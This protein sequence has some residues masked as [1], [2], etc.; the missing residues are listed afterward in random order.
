MQRLRISFKHLGRDAGPHMIR[1]GNAHPL[2]SSHPVSILLQTFPP[3]ASFLAVINAIDKMHPLVH[4]FVWCVWSWSFW[5]LWSVA[6]GA[7][8]IHLGYA[9]YTGVHNASTGLTIWKGIRY[10]QPPLGPLRW[11]APQPPTDTNRLANTSTPI[12]ASH[13]GPSCPQS[14]PNVPGASYLFLPGSEDCLFLNVYAPA[15]RNNSAVWPVLVWFHGGGYGEGDATQDLSPFL[16]ATRS[17]P[18]VTV[19]VQYRLGAF[20]FLAG[21]VVR[22]KGTLNAGLLD[23]RAALAWVQQYITLFGGDPSRVTLSGESAG[24]GS[25]LLHAASPTAGGLF[26]QI[27]AAS[28]WIPTQPRYDSA[29]VER[30]YR[31]FVA[32]S[33]CAGTADAWAC[34]VAQNTTTLQ[35]ASNWVSATAPTPHGNWAWLPVTDDCLL[36][37]PPSV[38]LQSRVQGT[39][40][41]I[42]VSLCIPSAQS[43]T[44]IRPGHGR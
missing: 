22:E 8:T 3:F 7:S 33:G 13:F 30:H 19:S 18:I 32:S 15:P 26:H 23:Q 24:A 39:H 38:L 29:V 1:S 10:A 37:G 6:A 4:S 17:A 42:G 12:L 43:R 16:T 21:T 27:W 35:W 9:A 20:G 14:L 31:D 28:P 40:A 2:V 41:L 34:L 36:P 44:W 25:V 11:Q 5:S